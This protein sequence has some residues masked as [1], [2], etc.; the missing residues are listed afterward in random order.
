MAGGMAYIRTR[1][2]VPAKRGMRVDAYY[3]HGGA[4][5]LALRGRITSASHRL[6]LNGGGPYHPTYGLVYLDDEGNVLCDTRQESEDAMAT[7]VD[8]RIGRWWDRSWT[9]VAGCTWESGEM[10]PACEHCWAR[11]MA[12]RFSPEILGGVHV[13]EANLEMP[14]TIKRPSIIACQIHYGDLFHP[15]VPDLFIQRA[16]DT[17]RE[18]ERHRFVFLTKRSKRAAKFEISAPNTMLVASVWDQP[19]AERAVD[20]LAVTERWGLHIEPMLGPVDLNRMAILPDWVAVGGESGRN[21]RPLLPGWALQIEEFCD[22]RRV[23]FFFK[24]W[25]NRHMRREIGG[26]AHDDLPFERRKGP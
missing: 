4:W 5:H 6:H 7:R 14:A 25:G 11:G 2:G 22:M 8:L 16:L 17:A 10:P 21:A 24:G 20:N 1:Y 3:R 12:T 23:P 15:D 26:R 19:S 13:V 9:L 18:I